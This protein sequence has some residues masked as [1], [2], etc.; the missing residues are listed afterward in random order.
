MTKR[1]QDGEVRKLVM[2]GSKVK[3]RRCLS[4]TVNKS[5]YSIQECKVCEVKTVYHAATTNNLHKHICISTL[6]SSFLHHS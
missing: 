1:Q 2:A 3:F 4:Y 6:K 5:V